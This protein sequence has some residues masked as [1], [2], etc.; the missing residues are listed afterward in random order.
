M[1][2]IFDFVKDGKE[3]TEHP[4]A[5]GGGEGEAEAGACRGLQNTVV[6]GTPP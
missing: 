5:M 6:L 1:G 3:R 4:G 2:N